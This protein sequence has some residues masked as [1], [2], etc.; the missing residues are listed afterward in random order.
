L[1]L[2]DLVARNEVL[3]EVTGAVPDPEIDLRGQRF[4]NHFRT[5]GNLERQ[6][7]LDQHRLAGC[8]RG[9]GRVDV[10][11]FGRGNDDRIDPGV[12]DHRVRVVAILVRPDQ[13]AE[14]ASYFRRD[15]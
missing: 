6:W 9:E 14:P 4:G 15:I 11:V 3:L 2:A 5:A 12:L 7:L 1:P 13:R 8:D 10:G